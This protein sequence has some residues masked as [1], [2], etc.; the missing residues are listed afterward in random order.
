MCPGVFAAGVSTQGA[1]APSYCALCGCT[2]MRA[3]RRLFC[4]SPL[5]LPPSTG[6]QKHTQGAVTIN[7]A[8]GEL[9]RFRAHIGYGVRVCMCVCVCMCGVCGVCARCSCVCRE[10]VRRGPRAFVGCKI[11]LC[12]GT[13]PAF[14][15]IF[16]RKGT[17]WCV[18]SARLLCDPTALV[19]FALQ[20]LRTTSCSPC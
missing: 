13:K 11:L 5:V 16:F 1:I 20:C 12:M 3:I 17:R 8:P 4:L 14:E 7:G 15:Q 19:A 18:E 10:P 2:N 6:K 9:Q